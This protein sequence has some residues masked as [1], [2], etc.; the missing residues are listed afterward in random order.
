LGGPST[1]HGSRIG[2]WLDNWRARRNR[3]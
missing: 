2:N 3:R 1:G